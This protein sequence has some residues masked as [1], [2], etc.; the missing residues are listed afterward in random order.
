MQLSFVGRR[1]MK[2]IA[3]CSYIQGLRLSTQASSTIPTALAITRKV[4]TMKNSEKYKSAEAREK[5]FLS[6]CKYR[7]ECNGCEIRARRNNSP[8]GCAFAWLDLEAKEEKPLPCPYCGYTIMSVGECGEEQRCV[9][10]ADCGYRSQRC[11]TKDAAIARH[12]DLCRKLK[13]EN[14]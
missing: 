9:M 1:H 13:G 6:H 8:G 2:G 5:A 3:I 11:N 7:P 14:S 4:D 10:C 12:N